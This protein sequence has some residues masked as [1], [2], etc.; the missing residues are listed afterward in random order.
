M[1]EF[2]DLPERRN[3]DGRETVIVPSDL[4]VVLTKMWT[5]APRPCLERR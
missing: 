3:R 5:I 2:P 1:A 4:E